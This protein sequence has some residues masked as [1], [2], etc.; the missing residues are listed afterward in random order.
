LAFGLFEDLIF[1]SWE[2]VMDIFHYFLTKQF[3]EK[4]MVRLIDNENH[5]ELHPY[6]YLFYTT[7]VKRLADGDIF[8]LHLIFNKYNFELKVSLQIMNF[9]P[10]IFFSYP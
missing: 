2:I 8:T 6:S 3:I 9:F 7:S 4:I 1:S 10:S 5:C